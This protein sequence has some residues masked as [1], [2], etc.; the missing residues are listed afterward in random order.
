MSG[1]HFNYT[2]SELRESLAWIARD[3]AIVKRWPH[4]GEIFKLLS[5]W[6]YQTVH[7]IDYDLSSDASIDND[8]AF[9]RGCSDV[10]EGQTNKG[11]ERL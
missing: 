1:G 2:E 9:D 10:M 8:G 11:G 4:L 7:A 5:E 3:P 6:A